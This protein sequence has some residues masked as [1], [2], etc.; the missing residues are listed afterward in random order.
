VSGYGVPPGRR[1]EPEI[2]DARSAADMGRPEID[3]SAIDAVAGG[4][5]R[6][7]RELRASVAVIARRTEDPTL[8]ELCLAVLAGRQSVRRVFE[9]PEFQQMS[10]VSLRH[11]EEGLARL[12]DDDREDL[13]A[14]VGIPTLDQDAEFDLMEGRGLPEE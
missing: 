7:A 6:A 13:L 2:P 10:M 12:D 14:R 9:H 8:R 4:D 11:L 1:D 5:A 3:Y